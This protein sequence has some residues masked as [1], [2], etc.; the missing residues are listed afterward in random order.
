MAHT[1]AEIEAKFWTAL[2]KDMTVMLGV[3]RHADA[4]PMTAQLRGDGS[5]GPIWF[6]TS[7]DTEITHEVTGAVPATFTFASK[8]HDVWANVTGTIQVDMDRAAIDELWNP[9]VAAWYEG[10]KDDPKLR[11]LRFDPADAKIWLDGS[12]LVAG[13]MALFGRD[14]KQS[15]QDNVAE[16]SLR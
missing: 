13:V 12:S 7:T 11:L 14:P 1:D 4:R 6:F 5:S 10:G 15:Y 2:K 16:V 3:Q 9:Y 8:G